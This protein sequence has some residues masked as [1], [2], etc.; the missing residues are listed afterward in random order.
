[1]AN[2]DLAPTILELA[3]ATVPAELARTIDGRSI[4]PQL[5]GGAATGERG[6]LLIEGR[7]NV[8]RSRRSFKVRSYVGTRTPRYAYIEHRRATYPSEPAGR[9]AP[10]GGGR[11]TDVELY[12]LRRD[13]LQLRS[14][15]RDRAYRAVRR[16]LEGLTS[17][18]EGCA[19]QTCGVSARVPPPRR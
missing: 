4:V 8:A 11:M 13:P 1:V 19:G 7:K 2:I 9:A 14:R 3:G 12:D 16:Q 6:A 10:I 5:T 18:L 15:H 17:R